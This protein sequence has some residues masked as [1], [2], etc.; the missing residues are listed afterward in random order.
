MELAK[1]VAHSTWVAEHSLV[2]WVKDDPR[3]VA[4]MLRGSGDGRDKK[5]LRYEKRMR[6]ANPQ[7]GEEELIVLFSVRDPGVGVLETDPRPAKIALKATRNFL[8]LEASESKRWLPGQ[9]SIATYAFPLLLLVLM[10]M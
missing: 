10:L 2:E 5:Y 4:A 8:F 3:S 1:R 9:S 6:L 7:I